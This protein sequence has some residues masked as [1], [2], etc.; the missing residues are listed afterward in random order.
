VLSANAK[1]QRRRRDLKIGEELEKAGE[2]LLEKAKVEFPKLGT[3]I[4]DTSESVFDKVKAGFGELGAKLNSFW[5]RFKSFSGDA[6]NAVEDKFEESVEKIKELVH[7][8]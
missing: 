3:S 5:S 7:H 8:E 6:K 1:E 4:K 2:E